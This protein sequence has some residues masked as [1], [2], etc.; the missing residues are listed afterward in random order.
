MPVITLTAAVSLSVPLAQNRYNPHT[1]AAGKRGGG[2]P[3]IAT[4]RAYMKLDTSPGL[5]D[6]SKLAMNNSHW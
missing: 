4:V 3:Y 6:W 5:T 2:R 1:K